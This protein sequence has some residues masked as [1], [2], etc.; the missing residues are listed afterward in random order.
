[1]DGPQPH[2][3]QTRWTALILIA[4]A[5]LLGGLAVRRAVNHNADFS[6]NHLN[7]QKNLQASFLPERR[8]GPEPQDPD[9]YPP[10]TYALYAPLGALPLWA[11]ATV[12]FLVNLGCSFYLWRG[13]R[14]WLQIELATHPQCATY[15]PVTA[16]IW[17]LTRGPQRILNLAVLAIL[18]AW[19]GSLLLGQ[20]ML[21]LMALTWGAFQ[22]ARNQ[23]PWLAGGLLALATVLKVLPVVFL[24]PYVLTRNVRVVAAFTISGC[25]LVGGLGSLYFGPVTNR[26]FHRKWLKF[27]VQGPENREPDPRDPNTLRGSL[28]YKNQS[29]EAVLARLMMDVPI[30]NQ[31]QAPRVNFMH[32][33]AATW[34]TT[35]SIVTAVCVMLGLFALYRYVRQT[36]LRTGSD[37]PAPAG[38]M[39]E[40]SVEML[41]ILSLLQLLISPMVWS[42]YY[43]WLFW[44]WLWL[45]AETLCGRRGGGMIYVAWL[46]AMPLMAV[47]EVRA[48]GLHLWLTLALFLWICWPRLG[49]STQRR[50]SLLTG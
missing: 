31:H 16:G 49:G 36:Q 5:L 6:G 9:A 12:W 46:I 13:A 2:R 40:S 50:G 45:Q 34:R 44:P 38:P 19:I 15:T 21:P 29:I 3:F 22:L 1:M 35:R 17:Q 8:D 47:P 27:A 26:E 37:V 20:N 48:M 11:A 7:W 24:L 33:S 30:H 14:N 4:V 18:P 25:L 10:I 23:R 28:R 39:G 43:V 41:A 32:L 42:H